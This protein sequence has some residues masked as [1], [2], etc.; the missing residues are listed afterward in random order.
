MLSQVCVCNHVVDGNAADDA[1][2]VVDQIEKLPGGVFD[3]IGYEPVGRGDIGI[4]PEIFAV[5]GMDHTIGGDGRFST[6]MTD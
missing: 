2:V 1:A 6:E 4:G 3:E 5:F